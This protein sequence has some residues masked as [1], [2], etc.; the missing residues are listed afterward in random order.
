[1]SAYAGRTTTLDS[2]RTEWVSGHLDHQR[3]AE[4]LEAAERAAAEVRAAG[5][6]GASGDDAVRRADSQVERAR[7]RLAEVEAVLS[8]HFDRFCGVAR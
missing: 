4:A 5:S 3:A 8:R 7:L 1:M 6:L 2:Y